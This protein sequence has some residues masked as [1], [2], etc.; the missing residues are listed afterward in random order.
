MS[1]AHHTFLGLL[2]RLG[3]GLRHFPDAHVPITH[4]LG[5]Q[6][7]GKKQLWEFDLS[8]ARTE[9]LWGGSPQPPRLPEQ[10]SPR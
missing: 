4:V 7:Q 6:I 5:S 2:T 9:L 3:K 10:L 8:P 1:T